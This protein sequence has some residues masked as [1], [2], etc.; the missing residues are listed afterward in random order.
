MLGIYEM[1]VSPCKLLRRYAQ[2]Q[3]VRGTCKLMQQILLQVLSSV[4]PDSSPSLVNDGG[5]K[6]DVM[7]CRRNMLLT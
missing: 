6:Y 7:T 3:S 2:C 1:L 5:K 4:R